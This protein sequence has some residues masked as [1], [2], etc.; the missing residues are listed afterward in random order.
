MRT[1]ISVLILAAFAMLAMTGEASA[2]RFYGAVP[3]NFEFDGDIEGSADST[4]GFILGVGLPF[5]LGLDYEQVTATADDT[6]KGIDTEITY[7]LPDLLVWFDWQGL[8]WQ[9]GFGVGSVEMEDF[10]NN[11]GNL[12][13]ADSGDA[14]QWF[15]GAGYLFTPDFSVDLSYRSITADVPLEVDGTPVGDFDLSGNFLALGVSIT[16]R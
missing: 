13:T 14:T 15:V 1:H 4:E 7:K 10:Q 16:F 3:L 8:A 5:G 9:L 11:T 12:F 6:K 2:F